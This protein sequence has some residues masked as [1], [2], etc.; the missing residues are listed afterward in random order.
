MLKVKAPKK[1][2]Q[3]KIFQKALKG[4]FFA[5]FLCTN[6]TL[7]A[8]DSELFDLFEEEYQSLSV[9]DP[10]RGYNMFMHSVNWGLY[11]YLLRPI[12]EIYGN[13]VPLGYRLG[14]YN[15]FENL[16]FPVRFLAHLLALQPK[17]AMNELG[18]F[19]L[20]S[21]V[22]LG[23]LFDVASQNHLYSRKFDFGITFGIWGFKSGAY[24]VLPLLGP[25]NLRDA[26]GLPFSALVYPTTYLDSLAPGLAL[27]SLKT[28]SSTEQYKDGIDEI[29]K[30][31]INGDDY[32]L[33]RDAYEQRRNALIKG[34]L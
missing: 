4:F 18:R 11:D 16:T 25:S 5:L 7:Y 13:V 1:I 20:N 2:L 19:V 34:N 33:V 29:R 31:A 24:I 28:L 15:F 6:S 32:I 17:E 21:S 30:S 23:G 27:Y 26:L 3:K 14:I 9:Y 8:Q 10:L 12:A 22:G